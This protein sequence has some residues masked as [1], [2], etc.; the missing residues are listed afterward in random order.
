MAMKDKLAIAL[1]SKLVSSMLLLSVL[2]LLCIAVLFADKKANTAQ[3]STERQHNQ[4]I[5]DA[6][7]A[8]YQ[9]QIIAWQQQ[10]LRLAEL[11]ETKQLAKTKNIFEIDDWKTVA[12][13]FF[14]TA[15]AVCLITQEYESPTRE[16]CLPITY[17]SLKSL[18]QLN[19]QAQADV[20]MIMQDGQADHILLA[21]KVPLDDEQQYAAVAVALE[22]VD[23]QMIN[24]GLL[25][26][27]YVEITQGDMPLGILTTL[28][29]SQY[30]H[31]DPVVSQ[32]ISNSYWQVKLW[33]APLATSASL[34]MIFLPVMLLIALI[35][36]VREWWQKKLLR[37]DAD[38]L[39]EQLHDLQDVKLKP[40]YPLIFQE[41]YGVREFIQ[42][43]AIPEKKRPVPVD[44]PNSVFVID[45]EATE[46]DLSAET[47]TSSITDNEP[48]N[49]DVI[50]Y[51]QPYE[52]KDAEMTSP[53]QID[54]EM[55][56][57][58]FKS[59]RLDETIDNRSDVLELELND[60][61]EKSDKNDS[62]IFIEP[63][64]LDEKET[65]P[66]PTINFELEVD[67]SPEEAKESFHEDTQQSQ[68]TPEKKLE[69]NPPSAQNMPDE[70][71]FRAYDIRGIVGEQLT[72]PVMTLIGR[73]V[74]SQM[75]AQ[76]VSE[77]VVGHDGR[78]S[79]QPLAKAFM[80]G[81]TNTGC[82]VV[83]LGQ[84]PT[85]VVYFACEHLNTHSGAMI[86]GS[87]N[88]AN[89]NG[90]KLVIAGKTLE[91]DEVHALYRRIKT[92]AFE[93]GRGNISATDVTD[94]Y[95]QRI[96]TEVKPERKIKV[97][98]DC[99]NGV[100]GKVLPKVLKEIGCHVI[101]LFCEVD[102]RF[103]NH[104]PN[105]GEP[106]NLKS[107]ISEV[108][109]TGAELG[110]AVDGDGDRLGVVDTQGNII[111]PD[112]LMILFSR[113][114]LEKSPGAT[115]LYDVKS[116]SLL[117]GVIRFAGGE[118]M[119]VPSG[120]SI[121]KNKMRQYNAALAAEMSGHFFFNDR[122]YGF[123]D[124]T[125]A[126]ARLI[127][128]LAADPMSRTP[129]QL[130]SEI[131][132]RVSTPEIMVNMPYP[133]AK[134]FMTTLISNFNA[135]GGD[136][137]TVDGIRVDYAD[138]WGLVRISNTLPALTLRFEATNDVELE[139]IKQLFVEQ[140]QQVKPTLALKL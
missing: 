107:L 102:G 44:E 7:V 25:P 85:P 79:S 31:A 115:I 64:S 108:K 37:S 23:I 50:D 83:D 60:E 139:R 119:M 98:V 116:T 61:E 27:A 1:G 4:Q 74:G 91:G 46:A 121:I 128:L 114:V 99:G 51:D 84:V 75:L 103:P 137:S 92:G 127:E 86:T 66:E 17:A 24:P 18:R 140:M 26:G 87:H 58:E 125:Y 80:R 22:P 54:D 90:I 77:L 135:D 29:N 59:N 120:H 100:A 57:D 30:K 45:D 95:I 14:P 130:F 55:V 53:Q 122:W 28:G 8:S 13:T 133:E 134:R 112:Q 106:E 69:L 126:A 138:G 35:W 124:A 97:V 105:P 43:L 33:A 63:D 6:V 96:K 56:T 62:S 21:A 123:D 78:L 131:S 110:I 38:T 118:P 9:Q 65:S 52:N 109:S 89:Y 16:A 47:E 32:P 132:Q 49:N 68:L 2:V 129:T 72:V 39:E 3:E 41:F 10:T 81:V 136:V 82:H 19:T 48:S 111:W 42:Q 36:W 113:D 5:I 94:A 104:H 88:P 76:G 101:E 67:E 20:A 70:G 12:N 71:I 15:K 117:E 40:K 11:D 34:W 73:A 93:I